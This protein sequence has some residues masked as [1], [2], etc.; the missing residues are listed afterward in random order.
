MK[1]LNEVKEWERQ[2][3]DDLR[4]VTLDTMIELQ[5]RALERTIESN[6]I[7]AKSPMSYNV[8]VGLIDQLRY[9]APAIFRTA[10][11]NLE[12]KEMLMSDWK[13]LYGKP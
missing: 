6:A 7:H 4:Q 2:V 1:P 5:I 13:P 12:G 3:S 9:Y 11:L 10:E 8:C